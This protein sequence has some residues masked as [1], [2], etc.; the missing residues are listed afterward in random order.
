[1]RG[2][3]LEYMG[4]RAAALHELQQIKVPALG[5]NKRDMALADRASLGDLAGARAVLDAL[6]ADAEP[7][8]HAYLSGRLAW[9]AGDFEAALAHFLVAAAQSYDRGRIDIHSRALK[10]AAMLQV[11]FG[12]DEEAIELANRA[13]NVVGGHSRI[14][15][16]DLSLFLAQLYDEAGLMAEADEALE[17]AN[18]RLPDSNQALMGMVAR[19]TTLRMRPQWQQEPPVD[20]EQDAAALWQ[21]MRAFAD[22]DAGNARAQLSA[23]RQAGIGLDR[24]ADEAR[25]LE[26]QLGLTVAEASLIDPPLPPIS[27]IVLRREIRRALSDQGKDPGASR[28]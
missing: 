17:R 2:H 10:C 5:N 9:T 26:L 27:R 1:M 21:A 6:P 4:M 23:A 12:R 19:F 18:A 7:L 15:E 24:L 11:L 14:D 25:W 3:L 20:L 8:S 28:P 22:G 16:V 13:R